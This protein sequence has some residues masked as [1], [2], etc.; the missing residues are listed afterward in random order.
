MASWNFLKL[1]CFLAVLSTSIIIKN[2]KGWVESRAKLSSKSQYHDICNKVEIIK[3]KRFIQFTFFFVIFLTGI[4]EIILKHGLFL[5]RCNVM[6]KKRLNELFLM[7]LQ[8]LKTQIINVYEVWMEISLLGKIIS[9]GLS[10][11][12]Q[13][14]PVWS[15]IRV[16]GTG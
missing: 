1:F 14:V 11:V 5:R 9:S 7:W 10:G 4:W 8:P 15:G 3:K 2:I 6:R 12:P 13:Q 16:Q